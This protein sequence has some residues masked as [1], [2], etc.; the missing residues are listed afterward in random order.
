MADAFTASAAAKGR[1]VL[2]VD[3]VFTTGATARAAAMA[4]REAGA[5]RVEVLTVARAF[6]LA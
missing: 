6:S 5:V 4:L 3:D 1:E 2:L